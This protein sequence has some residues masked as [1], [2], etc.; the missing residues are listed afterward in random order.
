MI[1]SSRE[2]INGDFTQLLVCENKS[3]VL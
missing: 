1:A 2:Q 3:I